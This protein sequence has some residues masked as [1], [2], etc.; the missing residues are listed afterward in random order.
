MA[1]ICGVNDKDTG[2]ESG[3]IQG[4]YITVGPETSLGV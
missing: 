3:V 2:E 4:R 1:R